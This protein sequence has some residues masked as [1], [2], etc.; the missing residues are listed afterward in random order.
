[1]QPAAATLEEALR[2]VE[3]G[4]L[5]FPV[6]SNTT[7]RPHLTAELA[8]TLVAQ[9][10]SPVRFSESLVAMTDHGIDTFVHVGP[11]EVTAGMARKTVPDAS[12]LVVS[13]LEGV[14]PALDA[15]GTM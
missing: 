8:S 12:V 14:A 11:G 15:L 9:V 7:A 1:M 6:W 2:G 13:D 10:V 5:E 3:F 4:P